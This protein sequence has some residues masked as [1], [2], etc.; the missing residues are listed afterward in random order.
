MQ[1]S[2]DECLNVDRKCSDKSLPEIKGFKKKLASNWFNTRHQEIGMPTMTIWKTSCIHIQR[3]FLKFLEK[4]DV[5]QKSKIGTS[6]SHLHPKYVT[7][8][9]W[10][11]C[12]CFWYVSMTS[13]AR[14]HEY[15]QDA[16]LCPCVRHNS[17]GS[18]EWGVSHLNISLPI[19]TPAV[20]W[21]ISI[22]RYR[23]CLPRLRSGLGHA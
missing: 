14:M 17:K 21:P 13:H 8:G 23:P 6:W 22:G 18:V 2:A 7:Y 16:R 9:C 15:W 19:Y 11:E 1:H 12:V 20:Y 3:N 4:Q 10:C 5:E